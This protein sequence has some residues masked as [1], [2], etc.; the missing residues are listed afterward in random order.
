MEIT[1]IEKLALQGLEGSECFLLDL[2]VSP[3]GRIDVLID[4][5]KSVNIQDCV[6]LS[7]FIESSLDREKED[8]ELNVSSYGADA[9]FKVFKHYEK[10]IGRNVEVETL[11]GEKE[12]GKLIEA[13]EPFFSIEQEKRVP[14]TIGKGKTTV[15]EIK[16]YNVEQIK[17]TKVILSFK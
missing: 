11:D 2:K 7:R 3:Q 14:K 15:K 16:Q 13:H 8:F 12:Q 1:Q 4:S 17:K 10:N 5:L 9:P 6:K